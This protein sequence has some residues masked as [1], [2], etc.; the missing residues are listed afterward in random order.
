MR[1]KIQENM[2]GKVINLFISKDDKNK[3]RESVDTIFVDEFG[4][5]NDKFYKKDSMRSILITALDSYI[6]SKENN[7]HLQYGALGENILIDINPYSLLAGDRLTIGATEF[8]ITQNCTLC[9]GLS[10]LNPS[11]PKLL[12]NDRGVFAKAIQGKS[13]ISVGDRVKIY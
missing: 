12:K 9:K 8:E 4:I 1:L 5:P 3:T 11:L 6:L 7:I 10:I 13:K 2:L